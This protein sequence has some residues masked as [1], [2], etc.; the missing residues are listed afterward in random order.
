MNHAHRP[1]TATQRLVRWWLVVLTLVGL[2]VLQAGHCTDH[3]SLALITMSSAP[4]DA[5]SA[6]VIKVHEV[7]FSRSADGHGHAHG[8]RPSPESTA[9]QCEPPTTVAVGPIPGTAATAPHREL[10]CLV[11]VGV[12]PPL[13]SG[14]VLPAVALAAL[15]VIR[16]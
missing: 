14:R 1:S 8:E 12:Q 2:G 9:G 13:P 15:G 11:N 7:V 5:V 3:P 6:E 10:Y 4:H 16:T